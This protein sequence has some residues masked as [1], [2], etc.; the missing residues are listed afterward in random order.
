MLREAKTQTSTSLCY[1]LFCHPVADVASAERIR[2]AFVFQGLASNS[3][4]CLSPI[5]DP[6]GSQQASPSL[7]PGSNY[8]Q[9]SNHLFGAGARRLW[10]SS[11]VREKGGCGGGEEDGG[12][13][14]PF[15]VPLPTLLLQGR[16]VPLSLHRS[17]SDP[18]LLLLLGHPL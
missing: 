5:L 6:S 14:P 9:L 15:F 13:F 3:R 12:C 2:R 18:A 10:L 1:C 16:A 8:N 17:L 11:G 7:F 4:P